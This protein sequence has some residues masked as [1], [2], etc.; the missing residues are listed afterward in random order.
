[1]SFKTKKIVGLQ[2]L[3]SKG[4]LGCGSGALVFVLSMHGEP[5]TTLPPEP[6]SKLGGL[7]RGLWPSHLA[8]SAPPVGGRG[9]PPRPLS[10]GLGPLGGRASPP[11]ALPCPS[12]YSA[13]PAP[14]SAGLPRGRSPRRWAAPPPGVIAGA[15]S[16]ARHRGPP[17]LLSPPRRAT[18][19]VSPSGCGSCRALGVLP[20]WVGADYPAAR[21]LRALSR[22]H[23][24]AAP[25]ASL[26][27]P[28]AACCRGHRSLRGF[29]C[30][31]SA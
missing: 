30:G 25:S 18:R 20:V 26:H 3:S 23:R 8:G 10:V 19:P 5:L 12:P 22:P 29:R 28:C 14:G 21:P 17:R 4:A 13:S 9:A 24:R 2:A 15:A 27:S 6:S 11:V 7:S 1:M 31:G 16:A